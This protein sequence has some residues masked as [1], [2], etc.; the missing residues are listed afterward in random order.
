[1]K[2]LILC[3]TAQLVWYEWWHTSRKDEN[4]KALLLFSVM[5]TSLGLMAAI[6][7]PVCNETTRSLAIT[8]VT[9]FIFFLVFNV[10]GIAVHC[11]IDVIVCLKRPVKGFWWVLDEEEKINGCIYFFWKKG[12]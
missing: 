6:L 3:K 12:W 4:T 5:L 10:F 1:M 8:L 2:W 9:G 11:L 7:N